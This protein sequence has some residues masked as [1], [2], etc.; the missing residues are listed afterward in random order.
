VTEP[1]VIDKDCCG[2]VVAGEI[3]R[4]PRRSFLLICTMALGPRGR[5][6]SRAELLDALDVDLNSS[7]RAIDYHVRKTRKFLRQHVGQTCISTYRP[8]GYA[9]DGPQGASRPQS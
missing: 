3:I 4:P 5:V 6:W 7:Y 2:I 1:I 9:W 8:V